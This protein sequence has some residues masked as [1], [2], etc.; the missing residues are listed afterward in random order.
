MVH[1]RLNEREANPNPFVNFITPLP[2][3]DSAA[4]EDARQLLRALAAQVKPVMKAHGFT[5]NSFEEYEHNKVFLGRNWNAGETIEIVLRGAGGGYLPTYALM[6]TLCHELAHIKHMNHGPGFQALWAQLRREVREL[7]NKGYYGDGYWSSGTRLADSARTGGEGIDAG[8]LPEYLCGGAHSRA[9]P[10]SFGRRR[11]RRQAGPSNHTG[12]QTARKRKAGG[13]VTAKDAF[14]GGGRAL[15]EDVADEDAKKAGAGFRKK[16]GSKRAREE[17]ALAAERRLLALQQKPGQPSSAAHEEDDD[18][19]SDSDEGPEIQETDQ[20]RRRAM[21][22]SMGGGDDLSKLKA[23]FKDFEDDFLLPDA[24]PSSPSPDLSCDV[25]QLS[26]RSSTAA[27]SSGPSSK[28]KVRATDEASGGKAGQKS[29]TNFIDVDADRPSKK[30]KLSYGALVEDEVKYRKKEALGMVG[31]GRTLGGSSARRQPASRR[32]DDRERPRP[33]LLDL[34]QEDA[35]LG[36][37]AAEDGSWEC[38]VCTL[39]NEPGHLACS[40]CATP[41]G[42]S[43]W[44]GTSV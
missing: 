33:E 1:L 26:G 39:S 16:A 20:D 31:N 28:G 15:N 44:S 25:Q 24:G 10:A 2:A 21:Q 32:M 19:A 23:S 30:P 43:S 7:Q 17:R 13:R 6:S 38:L 11:R 5:V 34:T 37:P 3:R 41:R 9:R 36:S 40:A 27:T 29:I 14:L 8:D 35:L 22:E 42:E 18:G 4:E 12:A